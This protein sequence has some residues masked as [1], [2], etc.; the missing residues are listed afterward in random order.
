MRYYDAL[1]A[2]LRG[3]QAGLRGERGM[4]RQE[5]EGYRQTA[6]QES[7]QAGGNLF[8]MLERTSSDPFQAILGR[9]GTAYSGA[10]GA[11]LYGQHAAQQTMGPQLYDP[12]SG[13]NIGLQQQ[14]NLLNYNAALQGAGA[15]KDA[16]MMG[17]AGAVGGAALAA[18]AP[19]IIAMI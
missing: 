19:T 14:S 6:F 9:P 15:Q 10:Q 17:A 8:G 3:E 4:L 12:N 7:Q 18:F 2:G 13:I 16:G 11:Q 5:Q 1:G